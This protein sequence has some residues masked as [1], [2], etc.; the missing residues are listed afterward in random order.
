MIATYG[1]SFQGRCE[2]RWILAAIL[3]VLHHFRTSP[4]DCFK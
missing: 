1:K 4:N 2:I 3:Q